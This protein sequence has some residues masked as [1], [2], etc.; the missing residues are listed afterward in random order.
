MRRTKSNLQYA[1]AIAN[2]W[3][4]YKAFQIRA[5]TVDVC[6][7]IN[8]D[9]ETEFAVCFEDDEKAIAIDDTKEGALFSAA[10]RLMDETRKLWKLGTPTA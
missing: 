8:S 2:P 7:Y 10:H 1:H 5:L 3:K 6:E 4:V 9:F